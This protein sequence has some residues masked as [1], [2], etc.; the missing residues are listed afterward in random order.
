MSPSLP[1]KSK[2]PLNVSM[3]AF[4]TQTKD[5]CVNCRSFLID[6]SATF[7]IVVSRMIIRSPRHKI[8]SVTHRL[9]SFASIFLLHRL[10]QFYQS[11]EEFHIA[12]PEGFAVLL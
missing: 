5:V 4:T 6:G 2:N 9:S 3:Y 7:T 10:N 1:P 12:A 8:S 11:V